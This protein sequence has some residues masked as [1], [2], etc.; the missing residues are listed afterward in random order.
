MDKDIDER[1]YICVNRDLKHKLRELK[2]KNS[3]IMV[4]FI[5]ALHIGRQNE[6]RISL[7]RIQKET[8]LSKRAVI[9]ALKALEEK[10]WI[11]AVRNGR[12]TNKY[13]VDSKF[14]RMG[15]C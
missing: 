15:Y 9:L 13:I 12:K 11:Q 7:Q 10:G 8:G 4:F 5:L 2:G 3:I 14:V 6:V 1:K